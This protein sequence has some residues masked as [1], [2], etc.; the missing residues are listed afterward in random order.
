MDQTFSLKG[1]NGRYRSSVCHPSN[2]QGQICHD[3]E[4]EASNETASG[5]DDGD[6]ETIEVDDELGIVVNPWHQLCQR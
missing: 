5:I 2:N 4:V 6:K 3:S 1:L